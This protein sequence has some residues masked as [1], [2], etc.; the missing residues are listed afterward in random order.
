M[1]EVRT[2]D[3]KWQRGQRLQ[4]EG[5]DGLNSCNLFFTLHKKAFVVMFI[6]PSMLHLVACL[7]VDLRMGPQKKLILQVVTIKKSQ[8]L[9]FGILGWCLCYR[10]EKKTLK[11]LYSIFKFTPDPSQFTKMFY[12]VNFKLFV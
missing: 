5:G 2:R 7:L 9:Q 12:S 1:S 11:N 8:N 4:P 6:C 3:S 10:I